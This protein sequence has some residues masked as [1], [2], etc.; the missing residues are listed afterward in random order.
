[1]IV[2]RELL[3]GGPVGRRRWGKDRVKRKEYYRRL[4][5]KYIFE[6]STVQPTK[7]SLRRGGGKEG[8]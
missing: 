3:K 4:N 7:N 5:I 6:N 1:M 2:E 8:E